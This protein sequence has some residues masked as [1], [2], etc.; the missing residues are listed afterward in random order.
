[1]GRKKRKNKLVLKP[2]CFYCTR[3][4]DDEKVLIQHQKAKHFKCTECSRKLDTATGLQVHMQQVHKTTLTQVPNA[5]DGREN[6]ELIIY[7]MEGVPPSYI[8]EYQNKVKQKMGERDSRKQQRINWTQVAMAPTLE[9]FIQQ[10]KAGNF[11]FPGFSPAPQMDASGIKQPVVLGPNGL[12]VAAPQIITDNTAKSS[13]YPVQLRDSITPVKIIS[14]PGDPPEPV[15]V[16]PL[17]PNLKLTFS[18]E[19]VSIEELR[20]TTLYGYKSFE[21]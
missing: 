21:A 18:K 13:L 9:Q 17:G 2:F 7:G 5:M 16:P 11:Y 19:N 8:E 14:L 1:M 3:E 6:P 4:F 15:H 10:T 20:A 12:P